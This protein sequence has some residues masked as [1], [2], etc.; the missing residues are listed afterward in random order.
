MSDGLLCL[1]EIKETE[2]ASR[3]MDDGKSKEHGI[4]DYPAST[5]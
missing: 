1:D 4:I 2:K 5:F 3:Q